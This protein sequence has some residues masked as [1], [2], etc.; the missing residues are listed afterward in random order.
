MA[1]T[2][3][4][5]GGRGSGRPPA[6]RGQEPAGHASS[7]PS[8]P[9]GPFG[10]GSG[11]T[12]SPPF[13]RVPAVGQ[14][15]GAFADALRRARPW[16]ASCAWSTPRT[17][18]WRC[19]SREGWPP[20]PSWASGSSWSSAW[21]LAARERHGLGR[22]L[23]LGSAAAL[24]GVAVHSLVDFPL[25]LP[26]VATAAALAATVLAALGPRAPE[27]VEPVPRRSWWPVRTVLAGTLVLLAG[28]L[29]VP[30]TPPR[31]A[32][33]PEV[34]L[35]TRAGARPAPS[36]ARVSEARLRQHLRTRPGDAYGWMI[37]AWLRA[38]AG[39]HAAGRALARH[40]VALDPTREPLR[41]YLQVSR[42]PG[43]PSPSG[44][45]RTLAERRASA[46]PQAARGRPQ[47]R[48]LPQPALQGEQR[49][50]A[51][52]EVGLLRHVLPDDSGHRLPLQV[53]VD[54]AAR[55][56][57]PLVHEAA[58]GRSGTRPR[59]APR[60]PSCRARGCWGEGCPS[61]RGA[62]AACPSRD[63]CA[64]GRADPPRTP[65]PRCRG[66]ASAPRGRGPWSSDPS[67]RSGRRGGRS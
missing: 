9:P 46:G 40:A 8:I 26:A 53:L 10:W 7:V 12:A 62:A 17:I 4:P 54:R 15:L 48:F 19:W 21:S 28:Q 33:L 61:W 6:R 67:S 32:S 37:L 13:A 58:R 43:S 29:A 5:G 20:R 57:E 25:R 14:G 65:P 59:A 42:R 50:D 44:R 11:A 18:S 3:R 45:P 1:A 66:R 34:R 55:I 22:G 23:A 41:A 63:A 60:S 35:V 30:G 27:A 16:P 39:D 64:D 47:P 36:R 56:E 38:S 2:G 51:G 31:A 24:A 52:R 49:P